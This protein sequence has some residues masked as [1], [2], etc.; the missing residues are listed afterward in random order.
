VQCICVNLGEDTDCTAATAGSVWGILYGAKKIPQKW[1]D[2]IGRGIKTVTLN[3][4]ELGYFGN[5]LPQNVDNLTDRTIAIAEKIQRA[6]WFSVVLSDDA[7]DYGVLTSKDIGSTDQGKSIWEW[8]NGPRYDFDLLSVHID[9]GEDGP[10]ARPDSMKRI[11]VTFRNT[12][13]TQLNLSLKWYA[14]SDWEISP[15]GGFFHLLGD[16]LADNKPQTAEFT[17][18][19]PEF[20]RSTVRAVLE[21]T[22]E[23]R[24]MTALVPLTFLDGR[25]YKFPTDY[26]LPF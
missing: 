22:A 16:H 17:F 5:Q 7:S 3:L 21:I 1:I 24:P 19:I 20:P 4:G 25:L 8:S 14:P 6:N 9:Y 2:P 10:L 18:V 15:N 23:G 13:K 26:E 12:Y 11:R